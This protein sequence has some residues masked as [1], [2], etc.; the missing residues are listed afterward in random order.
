MNCD[1]T[2]AIIGLIG[3]FLGTLLG[4][5]LALGKEDRARRIQFV[6]RISELKAMA[7]KIADHEFPA[8]FANMQ[9]RVEKECAIVES[10]IKRRCRKRFAEGRKKCSE[11]QIHD[12]IADPNPIPKGL[13]FGLD[14]PPP[15]TYGKGKELATKALENL[16]RAAS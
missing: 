3:I 1:I 8:W 10:A 6:G 12:D 14:R 15:T 13:S 2:V 7:G 4:N 5:R 11:P 9:V 16:I